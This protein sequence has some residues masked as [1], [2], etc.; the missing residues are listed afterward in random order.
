MYY[1][2]K[3][4]RMATAFLVHSALVEAQFLISFTE[5]KDIMFIGSFVSIRKITASQMTPFKWYSTPFH[6]IY[7]IASPSLS[8]S[9]LE[10]R[11]DYE[12]KHQRPQ[13][14]HSRGP[15]AFPLTLVLL[16][17]GLRMVHQSVDFQQSQPSN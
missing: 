7:F 10:L 6:R 13:T 2:N 9:I 17:P 16:F 12:A 11:E 3:K 5:L 1:G 4:S 8:K 15:Q 14:M